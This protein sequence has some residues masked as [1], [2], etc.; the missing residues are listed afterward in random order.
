MKCDACGD[1]EAVIHIQQ[2]VGEDSV[3]LHLCEACASEKGISSRNDKIELSLSQL[4]T[5]L[6]GDKNAGSE[7][8]TCHSCGMEFRNFKKEGKLGCPECY[9]EFRTEIVSLLRKVSGSA[10]HTGKIP[11]RLSQFKTYLIDREELKKELQEAVTQEDYEAAA[12]LRDRIREL[13]EDS[14]GRTE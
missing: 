12:I 11:K 14:G 10:R 5:G 2:I 9:N 7:E 6:I 3:D 1:R 13:D 4:L 8:K